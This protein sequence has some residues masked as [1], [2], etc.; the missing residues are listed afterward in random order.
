MNEVEYINTLKF[1]RGKNVGLNLFFKI[2]NKY[3]SITNFLE[4]FDTYDN[5][6]NIKIASTD[7]IQKE[8]R[9][10]EKVGAKI[11]TYLDKEYPEYLK[12]IGYFPPVLTVR[13]NTD[14][15]NNEKLISI[16]GSRNTSINNFNFTIKIASELGEYGYKVVSGLAKGV[17]S[18]S[19]S[20]SLKTGTIAVIAGGIDNIYPKENKDLYYKILDNNGL[21]I[22]EN[23]FGCPPRPEYFP[24][25]NR[26][27]AGLSKG[28]VIVDAGLVSGSLNTAKLA[29][30]FNRE[31]MVFPGS[32]YDAR[33]FGSNKLLQEGAT[34]VINSKDIIEN[35][36][37]FNFN[38]DN[39]DNIDNNDII[40]DNYTEQKDI[41]NKSYNLFDC[42]K[43]ENNVKSLSDIILS[44]IDLVPVS[45]NELVNE[46]SNEF[47]I[48]DINSEI[49]Q[50]E[51][52][53]K[54]VIQ[55]DKIFIKN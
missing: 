3:K 2:L 9:E 43:D 37:Q 22:S 39:I 47:N 7:T 51:L 6:H 17:D 41:N 52:N 24:S 42:L 19:H 20:G 55:N 38:I 30:K 35:L 50:L 34:L 32:P 33:C 21:I 18:A 48:S 49:M 29:I 46:L 28:V 53:E 27:V 13:G 4:N 45:I 15:L 8:I 44:K 40:I 11:I 54:V 5:K 14:L 23:Y 1:I 25:R 12:N 26:I 36:E 16:V 31:L 10:T